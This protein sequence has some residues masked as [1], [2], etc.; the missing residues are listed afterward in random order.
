MEGFRIQAGN[1]VA[2]T[3]QSDIIT[4]VR[5]LPSPVFDEN[6]IYIVLINRILSAPLP[7]PP[8]VVPPNPVP[9]VVF[10]DGGGEAFPDSFTATGSTARGFAFVSVLN[11]NILAEVHEATHLTTNLTSASG[12][13]Y[14]LGLPPPAL[15]PGNID[16]K[17]LMQRHVLISNGNVSDSKRLWNTEVTNPNY[18]PAL[19][20]PVQID[21]IR[22]NLRFIHIF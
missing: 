9:A 18:N 17:N 3:S 7:A 5:N 10:I 14:D 6:D 8:V 21:E 20:I 22:D 12:G 4:E 13:H 15:G 2:S 16:G 19:V 1:L 11:T